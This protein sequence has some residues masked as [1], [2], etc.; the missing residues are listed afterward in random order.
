MAMTPM[1]GWA[2]CFHR[3]KEAAADFDLELHLELLLLSSVQCA[4]RVHQLV[5]WLSWMSPAVT[6][7]SF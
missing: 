2:S 6:S 3:G 1:A 7:P 4:G 5:F